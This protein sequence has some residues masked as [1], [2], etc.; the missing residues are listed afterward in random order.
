[1][2]W[3][4]IYLKGN[5]DRDKYISGKHMFQMGAVSGAYAKVQ[6]REILFY[7]NVTD[8]YRRQTYSTLVRVDQM[9]Q[10]VL[11]S[12]CDCQSVLGAV[13][14]FGLCSH[15]VAVVLK[16]IECLK[17]NMTPSKDSIVLTPQVEVCMNALKR[18][19]FGMSFKIK[20]IESSQYRK[21]FT[22]YKEK[23]KRL[24]LGDERYL[25]L[26]EEKLKSTLELI[27]LLGVYNEIENITIPDEKALFLDNQLKGMTFVENAECVNQRLNKLSKHKVCDVLPPHLEET[28]RNYQKEG[29]QFLA[30]VA[31]YGLGGILADEMGLGKTLQVIAFLAVQKGCHALV[32]V[33]TAL[34]YNWQ[35]EFERF[36]PEVSVALVHGEKEKRIGLIENRKAYDVVLTTYHT[37]KNDEAYYENE[38]WDYCILDEA[39]HIKNANALLSKTMKL[40][41][42]KVRFALTG[43]PMENN[44]MELWS[45]MDFVLPGYLYQPLR[46]QNIFMTEPP[47]IEAL[48]KLIGPFMLRRTK[49]EV[50]TEL[51]DKIEQK[52]YI[53]LEGYHGKAYR[54]MQKLIQQKMADES[55]AQAAVLAYLTKLR[56]VCLVPE[57]LVKQ[58][59]GMNSK[60]EYL[61]SL[62]K[63][64]PDEKVLIFSQFTT[65]LGEIG[66][67]L[68]KEEMAY[69]Y[70]DGQTDA[71]VRL[72]RVEDFNQ[73]KEKR[74]FLISL[75]AGGTGLN[76]TSASTVIH[77]DPWW[78]PAVEN[79]ASDRAH[80]MG[81]KQVVNVMK[82]VAK[83]TIEESIVALQEEK[84]LLI[85]EVMSGG[86]GKKLSGL[87]LEE[88]KALLL[89]S[90]KLLG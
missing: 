88:M 79:Q 29:V 8:E 65:V 72:E 49:K 21:I 66:K 87:S 56:Q 41:K 42:S 19:G 17:H 61:M 52:V 4:K 34:V 55:A 51:P 75:K 24:Y 6:G 23:K 54:A 37:Y 57:L 2:D 40:I 64:I 44:M 30:S 82:L 25:N 83:G 78:N 48:R 39:Q 68:E 14:H 13:N 73:N 27:D 81:Q 60:L 28:L 38:V 90:E 62:L 26:E 33:P 5:A 63:E 15:G 32:I 53:T 7:G 76:L 22:A 85:E 45:I 59:K 20:G 71:K 89:E 67:R 69:H 10:T 74:I 3:L 84:Q 46:F 77:F 80:R 47:Q 18:G 86:G 9:R 35:K 31:Q 1:M 12:S 36:A 11:E 16:G 70:L 43:T 58:Y 50:L